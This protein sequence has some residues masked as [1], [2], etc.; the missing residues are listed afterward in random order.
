MGVAWLRPQERAAM[1]MVAAT[2]AR[3]PATT[4]PVMLAC[5]PAARF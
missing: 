2:G 3:P 1:R 5:Y 4:E